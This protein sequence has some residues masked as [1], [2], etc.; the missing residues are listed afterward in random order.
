MVCNKLFNK[1]TEYISELFLGM[2]QIFILVLKQTDKALLKF[3][4]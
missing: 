4:S 1:D 3:C 2:G